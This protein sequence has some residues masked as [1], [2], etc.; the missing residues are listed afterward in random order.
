MMNLVIA[1]YQDGAQFA[2]DQNDEQRMKRTAS[3]REEVVRSGLELRV[4]A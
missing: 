4:R 1:M 2:V 3:I